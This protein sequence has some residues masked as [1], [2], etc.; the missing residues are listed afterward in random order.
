MIAFG[1]FTVS[2]LTFVVTLLTL[3]KKKK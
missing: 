1:I 3:F 2:I